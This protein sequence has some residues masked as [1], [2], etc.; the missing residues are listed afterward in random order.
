MPGSSLLNT[1]VFESDSEQRGHED[2]LEMC[3]R[4]FQ[5]ADEYRRQ[6]E[7]KWEEYE[8]YY[9]G[10]H[11]KDDQRPTKNFIFSTVETEVP[12][13]TDS[14]PAPDVL[15]WEMDDGGEEKAKIL[16]SC[17]TWVFD[18][19]KLENKLAQTC[20]RSLISGTGYLYPDYDPDLERGEGA[21]TIKNL[22]WR[23]VW[24][25][26][27]V[28]D[29]D[30]CYYGIIKTPA[31]VADI[32]RQFKVDQKDIPRVSA[33]FLNN[34]DSAN[35]GRDPNRW[36]P[37]SAG[38]TVDKYNAEDITVLEEYWLKD[39]SMVEIDP[40][41]TTTE[42]AKEA[43]QLING[44][45][46][47]IS[48]YEDHA[49]HMAAHEELKSIIV[50]QKMNIPAEMMDDQILQ[51]LQEQDEEIFLINH[52]IDDHIASHKAM[53]EIN[54][55]SKKPKYANNLRLIIKVDKMV[56]YDGN[57]PVEDDGMIPLV[58]VYCYKEED[59]IYGFGEVKNIL[60]IQKSFNEMDRSEYEA[61]RLVSNP[62]WIKDEKSNVDNDSLTNEPGIVITTS[63]GGNL[64]RLEPGQV[65]PQLAIRKEEDRQSME[66]IS[67]I[68]EG[69]QGRK[70]TGVTAASAIR[71][72]Q[73]QSVGRVRLKTRGIENDS[74]LRLGKLVLNRVIK[75]WSTE[76]KL[77]IY[78]NNR[79]IKYIDF[80]PNELRGFKYD[81][82]V[83]PGS[84]AGIDK[85][86]IFALYA[87]MLKN[88]LITPKMFF[89][90]VD[91]PYKATILKMLEEQDQIQMQM[92]QLAEENARLKGEL[93]NPNADAEQGSPG[94]QQNS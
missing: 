37:P 31:R 65:S 67:G 34:T 11:W 3:D 4:Y 66:I 76:R 42:I 29:I 2:T 84:T 91:I 38:D 75:Y 58:P 22:N 69:T 36:N 21:V 32:A 13:L 52:I 71:A 24:L 5:E 50:S 43:E 53:M 18:Q 40:Q 87:D 20:R 46:P 83:V 48:K 81:V 33:S 23:N 30:D 19:Q 51:G 39:Y 45:N 44:I 77:R 9:D 92:G 47:D 8:R 17:L 89:T 12:I 64:K 41:E 16:S 25:D 70:P 6:F 26:P 62:G 90:A 78:D 27:A 79:A 85:E 68:N 73:E 7:Q 60:P 88:Q 86:S 1:Q 94:E 49:E 93:P 74:M 56:L 55:D 63:N 35:N 57:P 14:R 61:L 59:K 80:R 28:S 82:K 15:P 72:L 10:N 54:P